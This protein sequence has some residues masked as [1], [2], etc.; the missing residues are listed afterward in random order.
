MFMKQLSYTVHNVTSDE[1]GRF[2]ILYCTID[3]HKILIS[4]V[5]APNVDDH[6]FMHDWFKE[7]KRF[8]P[9]FYILAGDLNLVID[10]E[11]DK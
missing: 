8:S 1:M 3:G 7:I 9:E 11:L 2:L 6:K 5:Y 10:L 4:N